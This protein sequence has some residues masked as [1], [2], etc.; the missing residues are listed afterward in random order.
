MSDIPLSNQQHNR[1][2]LPNSVTAMKKEAAV[3]NQLKNLRLPTMSKSCW[4]EFF[5]L[6][7]IEQIGQEYFH[8]LQVQPQI[9][10][11]YRRSEW[12]VVPDNS[13]AMYT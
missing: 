8:Q 13:F 12:L 10:T 6:A 2:I 7:S 1:L 4:I 9:L 3:R 5:G 11:G